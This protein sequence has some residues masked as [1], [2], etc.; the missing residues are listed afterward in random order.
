MIL[1]K[2]LLIFIRAIDN[3]ENILGGKNYQAK[4][5]N[6]LKAAHSNKK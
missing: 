5:K 6:G 2:L 4:F 3:T 1:K